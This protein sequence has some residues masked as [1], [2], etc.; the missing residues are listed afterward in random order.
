[1]AKPGRRRKSEAE[2]L[3]PFG[4]ALVGIF[5]DEDITQ[6]HFATASGLADSTISQMKIGVRLTR[7]NVL[8]VIK[9]LITI[10]FLTPDTFE[11]TAN[12]LLELASAEP[13]DTSRKKDAE[14]ITLLHEIQQKN[15]ESEHT[16]DA[17]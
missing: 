11:Y 2:E 13:L 17:I 14:I 16:S 12:K 6:K 1:M 7:E 9:G 5:E 4:E 10:G 8:K 15:G 3:C